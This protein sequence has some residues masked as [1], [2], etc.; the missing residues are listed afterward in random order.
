MIKI[1]GISMPLDAGNSDIQK[2]LDKLTGIKKV[3]YTIYKK[4]VDARKKRDIRFVY[5]VILNV[6]NEEEIL[7]KI[8]GSKRFLQESF[9]YPRLTKKSENRPV[10]IGTGPAGTFAALCLA[11][12]GAKPIIIERGK[13]VEERTIDVDLFFAEGKLNPN[14][15]VQFG[16]GGA[17]TFSDGK[18]NTGVNNKYIRKILEEYV[19]FGADEGILTDGKPH[20]GTDVLRKIA[21]NVRKE[22][23]ALGG[24]YI[25]ESEF[26]NFEQKD[27]KLTCIITKKDKVPAKYAVLAIGH[28]AR[29]T[30]DML[31]SK[32]VPMIQKPFSVGVRIEHPQELI[33][34][35]QY[36]NFANHPA[37]KNADYKFATDC[38]S[39]CMCPGGFVVGAS[40]EENSIVTNG[41]SYSKRDGENANSALLVNVD[42]KDFGD[43]VLDGMYFQREI[44][45]KA[46][47][48]TGSYCAP[49]QRLEDFFAGRKSKSAGA[50]KPTY[51]PGVAYENMENILPEKV[52]EKLKSG[53]IDIDRKAKG[54]NF[55]DSLL[56]GPE[57]RSSSPV[58]IIRDKDTFDSVGLTGLFPCGEGAGYAGGIMSA[59]SD[60][61]RIAEEIINRMNKE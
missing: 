60:G 17:G 54:F 11:K 25:F 5:S 7:N 41:M 32:G 22:I 14:S 28:S 4:A 48:I 13:R 12:A 2:K 44:E 59:A 24:E 8:S 23:E 58:R 42:S 16:E 21:V 46:Y 36:G 45:K 34:K 20:I 18:L 52:C 43:G 27:N 9:E 1:D 53:I 3:N 51:A 15:N 30:F 33:N 6:E 38:Y 37:L 47:K 29:D 50:V 39:F 35:L 55:P 49:C 26:C 19:A 61:L 40:S 10:V 31:Y 57:T 56:T